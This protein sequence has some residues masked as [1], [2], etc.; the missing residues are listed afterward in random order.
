MTVIEINLA[1]IKSFQDKGAVDRLNYHIATGGLDNFYSG[2]KVCAAIGVSRMAVGLMLQTATIAGAMKMGMAVYDKR[3]LTVPFFIG[4]ELPEFPTVNQNTGE[5]VESED[6]TV[7]EYVWFFTDNAKAQG[8]RFVSQVPDLRNV[9]IL[10]YL[11]FV[12]V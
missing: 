7:T 8:V 9:L 1:R 6:D 4:V 12:S 3:D 11:E 2:N 10:D 5:E